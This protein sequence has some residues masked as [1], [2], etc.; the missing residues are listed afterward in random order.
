[1]SRRKKTEET[2]SPEATKPSK[3]KEVSKKKSNALKDTADAIGKL[4]KKNKVANS[5]FVSLSADDL[6]KPL[7]HISTGSMV[8]NRGIT[9]S[10]NQHGV[11][12]SPGFPRGSV[13]NIYGHEGSGKTTLALS[14]CAETCKQGGSVLYVDWE[15]AIVPSY[16]ER[17]GVPVTDPDAFS[18][19]Q[20]ETLE[21]GFQVIMTAIHYGVDMIVVDSVNAG[22]PEDLMQRS[23]E[24]TGKQARIGLAAQKWSQVLP[25]M[26]TMCRKNPDKEKHTVLIGISQIRTGGIGSYGGPKNET[27]G[28]KAW[29][30]YSDLRIMLRRTAYKKATIKDPITGE[31]NEVALAVSIRAKLEKNKISNTQNQEFDYVL[32][33]GE[34]IDDLASCEK[35]LILA[36]ELS[37]GGAWYTYRDS[38][39]DNQ[40][41]QGQERLRA[42]FMANPKEKDRAFDITRSFLFATRKPSEVKPEDVEDVEIPEDLDVALK[43]L[44]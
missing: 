14:A 9:G 27:A 26:R 8:L 41:L 20:P 2:P 15:H 17:I 33:M 31:R 24:E 25:K 16:A 39:G 21:Q 7:P 30:F 38:N 32:R 34:G 29:K 37:K 19:V 5:P 12:V 36:G 3:S 18:L 22:V 28:G 6:K 10:P 44:S 23:I 40:R 35:Y 1:M 11:L 4:M 43:G 42:Y 13:V